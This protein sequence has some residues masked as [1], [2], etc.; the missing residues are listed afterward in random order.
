[1]LYPNMSNTRQYNLFLGAK[2]ANT[3]QNWVF[4]WF[5]AYFPRKPTRLQGE[6]WPEDAAF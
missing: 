6:T 4:Q 3:G 1:M 2:L 5:L